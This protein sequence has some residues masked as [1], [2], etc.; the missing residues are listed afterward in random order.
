MDYTQFLDGLLIERNL[1]ENQT[2]D[3]GKV[4][5]V[6][7]VGNALFIKTG[8]DLALYA[9]KDFQEGEDGAYHLKQ[10][11]FEYLLVPESNVDEFAIGFNHS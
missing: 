6:E 8:S 2:G 9:E 4:T 3:V 1:G 5:S 10:D 11:G 7:K